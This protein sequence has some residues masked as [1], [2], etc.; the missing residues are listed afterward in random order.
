MT[1]SKG[2]I[3]GTEGTNYILTRIVFLL[4]SQPGYD[5]YGY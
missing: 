2:M 1:L 3:V 4:K 5:N